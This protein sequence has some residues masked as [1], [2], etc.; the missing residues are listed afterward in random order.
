MRQLRHGLIKLVTT[1][2]LVASVGCGGNSPAIDS[3]GRLKDLKIQPTAPATGSA[4]PQLDPANEIAQIRQQVA[5]NY[6]R[7]NNLRA[8]VT[9]YVKNLQKGDTESAKLDYWFQKPNSTALLIKEHSPKAAAA[10]TKMVWMG[11]EKLAIKTKFIGFWVKTSLPESDERLKDTRGDRIS[12]TAVPRMMKAILDPRAQVVLVG[13]GQFKGRPVVQLSL[14]S[15]FSL[16]RVESER[17][18]V[19]TTNYLPVVREMYE[20]GKL[21]YRLQ[22]EGI[23]LNVHEPKAFE[24]E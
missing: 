5:F 2:M 6:Q 9:V 1:A 24:L 21:T 8:D 13:R 17:I 3:G 11:G 10:G 18:S 19:D 22:L 15:Q 23:K 16:P 20:G 14:K 7:N 12:E 4:N